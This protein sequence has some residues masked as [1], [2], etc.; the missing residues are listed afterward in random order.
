MPAIGLMSRTA[1][2][3]GGPETNQELFIL[4]KLGG[5]WK[6]ARYCFCTTKPRA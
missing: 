4:Q 6:I 2:A 5:D 1:C 3:Q